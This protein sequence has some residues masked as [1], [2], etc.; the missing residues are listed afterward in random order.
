MRTFA[1]RIVDKEQH[2]PKQKYDPQTEAGA[3]SLLAQRD[4]MMWAR[5]LIARIHKDKHG[6]VLFTQSHSHLVTALETLGIVQKIESEFRTTYIRLT[7]KG[8]AMASKANGR[9]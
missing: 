9:S 5:Q 4:A 7:G 8:L 2:E 1:A 3:K 6:A